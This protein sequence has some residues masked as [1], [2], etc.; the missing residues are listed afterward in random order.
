VVVTFFTV[1]LEAEL[2]PLVDEKVTRLLL[3]PA[4]EEVWTAPAAETAAFDWK[5]AAPNI[6]LAAAT[7]TILSLRR[8]YREAAMVIL[9]PGGAVAAAG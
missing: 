7:P 4:T 3:A 2:D 8:P 5:Y 1:W 9:F 6:T